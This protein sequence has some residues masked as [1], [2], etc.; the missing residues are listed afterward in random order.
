MLNSIKC[1]RDVD[2][3]RVSIYNLSVNLREKGEVKILK[4]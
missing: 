4:T 3:N 2:I 1:L